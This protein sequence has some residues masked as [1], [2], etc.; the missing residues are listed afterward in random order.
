MIIYTARDIEWK[1]IKNKNEFFSDDYYREKFIHCSFP[2]Q[3]IKVLNKHFIGEEI[4]LLLCINEKLLKS[5]YV[6]ED[7]KRRGEKFPHVYGSINSDSIIKVIKISSNLNEEFHEN[8][9]LK[10]LIQR[11]YIV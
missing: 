10:K 11:D 9:E 5:K 1:K 4:M 3:T 2:Y 8:E 6:V 7:I